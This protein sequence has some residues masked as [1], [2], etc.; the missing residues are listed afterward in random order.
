MIFSSTFLAPSVAPTIIEARNTSSTS[1]FIKWSD[2]SSQKDGILLG[3]HISY[4]PLETSRKEKIINVIGKT[5]RE[6]NLTNLFF[7]WKYEIK[8]G[9]F[10]R[11]GVGK[12]S[13]KI[14]QTDEECK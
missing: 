11:P 13:T 14:V 4:R 8:V 6:Y 3:Y 9:G 12:L 1:I 5:I 7:W 2:I 10:S